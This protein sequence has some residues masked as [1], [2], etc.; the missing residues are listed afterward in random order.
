MIK[1]IKFVYSVE[2]WLLTIYCE[3][4]A[5]GKIKNCKKVLSGC[6]AKKIVL[7]KPVKTLKS[8]NNFLEN[9]LNVKY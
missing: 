6:L 4:M 1:E 8:M 2:C 9:I 7:K 5:S 3:K